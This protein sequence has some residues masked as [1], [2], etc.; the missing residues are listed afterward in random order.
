[1]LSS[2]RVHAVSYLSGPADSSRAPTHTPAETDLAEKRQQPHS[3][4]TTRMTDSVQA[5][6]LDCQVF[7]TYVVGGLESDRLLKRKHGFVVA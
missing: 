2:N 5:A 3:M 7:P 6:Q 4:P 1:M